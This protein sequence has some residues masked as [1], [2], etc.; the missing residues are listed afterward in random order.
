MKWRITESSHGGFTVD[1]GLDHKGGE[2]IP[3]I[4]G[5]TMPAF[6]VYESAHF[7]TYKEAEKYAKRR[8][9]EL[10]DVI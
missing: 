2:R 5:F 1:R 10:G 3:G 8:A 4:L 9:K 6:I 7:D